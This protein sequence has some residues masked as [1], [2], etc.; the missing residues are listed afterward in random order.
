MM[1][2][3]ELH[4]YLHKLMYDNKG[5]YEVKIVTGDGSTPPIDEDSIEVKESTQEVL[6]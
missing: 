4:D 2:V 5:D 3:I 1:T 6:I